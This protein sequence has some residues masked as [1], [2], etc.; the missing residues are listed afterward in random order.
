MARTRAALGGLTA[1]QCE[2]SFEVPY[3]LQK[4]ARFLVKITEA[5]HYRRYVIQREEA[6]GFRPAVPGRD[7]PPQLVRTEGPGHTI[8]LAPQGVNS[9]NG[10]LFIAHNGDV[11]PSGFL[12]VRAGSVRTGSLASIYRDSEIFRSLRRPAGFKGICGV[13]EFN[14]VCGGS[15]SRAFA[16]TGDYLATDPWCAYRPAKKCAVGA[17]ALAPTA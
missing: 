16:L 14:A 13:C 6:A 4:E 5:P 1:A 2:E 10:F 9:G 17:A 11:F 15:R 7:L 12:P 3:R 8:G